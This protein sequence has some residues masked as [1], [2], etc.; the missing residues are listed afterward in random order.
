[1]AGAVPVARASCAAC[2]CFLLLGV[3]FFEWCI[4]CVWLFWR[5]CVCVLGGI[6]LV[7]VF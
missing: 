7:C 4:V 5:V 3:C 6:R 2:V 1:M